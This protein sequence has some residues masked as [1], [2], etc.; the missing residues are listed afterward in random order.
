MD[1][2]N[3]FELVKSKLTKALR[4]FLA[5]DTVAPKGEK[6]VQCDMH[7]PYHQV[8]RCDEEPNTAVATVTYVVRYI[9][10]KKHTVRIKFQYDQSAKIDKASLL[11]V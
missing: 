2:E 10:E 3:N 4:D 8:V 6:E 9:K 5:K 7:V 1:I 11:Y